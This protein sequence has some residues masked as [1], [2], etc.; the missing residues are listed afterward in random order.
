MIVLHHY[1]KKYNPETHLRQVYKIT[2]DSKWIRL[3]VKRK[4]A[5]A[6]P[7]RFSQGMS[8]HSMG[9]Q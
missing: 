6:C 2:A 8:L 1:N 7:F 9:S 5:Q 3:A 4:A